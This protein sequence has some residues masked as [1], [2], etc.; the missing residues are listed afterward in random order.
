MKVRVCMSGKYEYCVV[1]IYFLWVIADNTATVLKAPLHIFTL[2]CVL[3]V[4]R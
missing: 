3:F 2:F 4:M 1:Y